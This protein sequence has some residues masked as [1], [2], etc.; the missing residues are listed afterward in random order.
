MCTQV[1]RATA[2]MQRA[3][4]HGRAL[5]DLLQ[6]VVLDMPTQATLDTLHEVSEARRF[7]SDSFVDSVVERCMMFFFFVYVSP[8]A[9][10]KNL[11]LS[12]PC[13]RICVFGPKKIRLS[14]Y[15]LIND[16]RVVGCAGARLETD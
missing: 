9:G 11:S 8:P 6:K 13:F 1:M 10:R 14:M 16:F 3:Y 12:P 4:S 5:T 15:G 7:W 2:F